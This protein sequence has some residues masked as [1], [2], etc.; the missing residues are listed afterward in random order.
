MLDAEKEVQ[1]AKVKASLVDDLQNKN[2]ELMKQIEISQVAEYYIY[3]HSLPTVLDYDELVIIL[4]LNF[5]G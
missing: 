1:L 2:Q 4:M 3:R 5:N